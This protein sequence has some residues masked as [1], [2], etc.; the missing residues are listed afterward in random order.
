M[1]RKMLELGSR[2]SYEVD[3]LLYHKK[4]LLILVSFLLIIFLLAYLNIK[5]NLFKTE[6]LIDIKYYL[7]FIKLWD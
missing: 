7:F 4:F 2:K 6:Q 5:Y 3:V 1:C